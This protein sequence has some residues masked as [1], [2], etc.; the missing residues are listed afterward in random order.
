MLAANASSRSGP[1]VPLVPARAS[2]WQAPHLATKARLPAIRLT[3]SAPLTELEQPAAASSAPPA[4]S[5]TADLRAL[6][7]ALA[8]T[9]AGAVSGP[10]FG[11][12][13]LIGAREVIGT[14]G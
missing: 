2:V 4:S 12:A 8:R 11:R 6:R 10:F 3:L 9:P 13:K 14:S 5:S 1:T 7:R